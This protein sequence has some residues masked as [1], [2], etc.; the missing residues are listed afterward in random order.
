MVER[1]IKPE[2]ADEGSYRQMMKSVPVAAKVTAS[3]R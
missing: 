2:D 1:R 3:P